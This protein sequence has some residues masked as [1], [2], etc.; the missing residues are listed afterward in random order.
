MPIISITLPLPHGPEIKIGDV[1]CMKTGRIFRGPTVKDRI[2]LKSHTGDP[3][4]DEDGNPVFV[5][6][7]E[8]TLGY[9]V[10][11]LNGFNIASGSDYREVRKAA[12]AYR[13]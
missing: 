13:R 9:F 10:A 12:K 8:W 2:R 11:D 4:N 6:V 3:R 5:Y 1:I 7:W